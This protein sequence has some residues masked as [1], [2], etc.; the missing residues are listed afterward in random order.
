MKY[1]EGIDRV[2]KAYK[3]EL[4]VCKNTEILS[5]AGSIDDVFKFFPE[6]YWDRWNKQFVNQK[7]TSK[8]L[9]HDSDV[10]RKTS[11]FDKEYNRETRFLE[12]FPLKVNIDIFKNV[13]LIVSY[14]DELALWIESKIL[15]DS[16]RILFHSLWKTATPLR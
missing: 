5:A 9:V 13:V 7:S 12:Y 3:D 6:N 2:K 4:E 1:Y 10:A 16:C 14:Y 15:A 8:M 11:R